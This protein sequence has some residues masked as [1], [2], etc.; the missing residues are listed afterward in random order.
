MF[1]FFGF[2]NESIYD[3]VNWL[4]AFFPLGKISV[5]YG[6]LGTIVFCGY[7]VYDTYLLIERHSQDNDYILA[8]AELYL[9]VL[10]LFLSLSDLLRGGDD[11][12]SADCCE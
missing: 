10:N 8:A 9:D 4:Q 2:L 12:C 1:Q 7:I 3:V 6:A 11:G 5:M